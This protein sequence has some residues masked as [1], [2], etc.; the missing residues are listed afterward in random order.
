MHGKRLDTFSRLHTLFR[1]RSKTFTSH[2]VERVER[3]PVV[4]PSFAFAELLTHL[5]HLQHERY[6]SLERFQLSAA[7]HAQSQHVSLKTKSR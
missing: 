6:K 7:F 2:A 1:L 5:K 3:T 4:W